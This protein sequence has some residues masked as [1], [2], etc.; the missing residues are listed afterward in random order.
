MSDLENI[1]VEDRMVK[2]YNLEDDKFIIFY[3]M[4]IE[5]RP[6]Q[7]KKWHDESDRTEFERRTECSRRCSVLDDFHRFGWSYNMLNDVVPYGSLIIKGCNY[8]YIYGRPTILH[9][10]NYYHRDLVNICD[11]DYYDKAKEYCNKNRKDLIGFNHCLRF[12]S[13]DRKADI[14]V[15]MP[16]N[17]VN[18]NFSTEKLHLDE[19][20][21]A[22]KILL[23]YFTERG[24]FM[25]SNLI[26]KNICGDEI[27]SFISGM[28][29]ASKEEKE[30]YYSKFVY[31]MLNNS[32]FNKNYEKIS[33][34]KHK[35]IIKKIYKKYYSPFDAN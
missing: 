20:I 2:D 17:K 28:I 35:E 16:R 31:A 21:D 8:V 3:D 13:D 23:E 27:M 6:E 10:N 29:H 14:T 30:K 26:N 25:W 18:L 5:N 11:L 15:Y 7:I 12:R 19:N 4:S 9:G 33:D 34:P 22:Y 32:N 1:K 24:T